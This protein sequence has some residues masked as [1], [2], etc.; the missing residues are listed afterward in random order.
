MLQI[1]ITAI[2]SVLVVVF[3]AADSQAHA[4]FSH[5]RR[6]SCACCRLLFY[7]AQHYDW[8]DDHDN[9]DWEHHR[10]DDVC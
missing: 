10:D 2:L 3:V 4:L 5:H 8:G 9:Y 7:H 6:L 1:I